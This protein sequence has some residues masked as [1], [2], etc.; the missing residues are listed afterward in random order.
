MENVRADRL[1][2]ITCGL[3]KLS[4]LTKA[5]PLVEAA[6]YLV[7]KLTLLAVEPRV[8]AC[9]HAYR[10]CSGIVGAKENVQY[11]WSKTERRLVC[12][13]KLSSRKQKV[14]TIYSS[15]VVPEA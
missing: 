11:A 8:C 12:Y 6:V 1:C 3:A 7:H 13:K 14:E 10:S 15:S 2:A 4:N 5:T 9:T